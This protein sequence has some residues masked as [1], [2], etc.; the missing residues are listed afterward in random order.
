MRAFDPDRIAE[1]QKTIKENLRHLDAARGRSENDFLNDKDALD[2][3]KYRLQTAIQAMMDISNHLCAR[4]NLVT[5]QDTGECVRA[6]QAQGFF[7]QDHA[8]MYVKMIRFRNVLVHLYGEVDNKRVYGILENELDYFRM[9]LM[10]IDAVVEKPRQEKKG[11][12][13]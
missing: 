10:E 5:T 8:T 9:F 12:K 7:P 1:H 13:K 11:R 3:T 6:L 2:A 4:L